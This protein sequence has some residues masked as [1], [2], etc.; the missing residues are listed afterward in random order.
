M[1][2]IDAYITI[3]FGHVTNKTP[4]IKDNKNPAWGKNIYVNIFC[5]YL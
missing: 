2:S 1:G 3:S 5:N 4:V